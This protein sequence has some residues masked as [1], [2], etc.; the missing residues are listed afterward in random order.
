MNFYHTSYFNVYDVADK[1]FDLKLIPEFDGTT[2]SPP[3]CLKKAEFVCIMCRIKILEHY[4]TT[5]K[6]N[7]CEPFMARHLHSVQS[8][9]VYHADL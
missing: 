9:D 2:T 1:L 7:A 4:F 8:V 6:L 3:V 5:D